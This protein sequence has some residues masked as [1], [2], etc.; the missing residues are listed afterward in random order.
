MDHKDESMS[1]NAGSGESVSHKTLGQ[2]AAER[3]GH[4]LAAHVF[5]WFTVVNDNG[6][7]RMTLPPAG[8]QGIAAIIDEVDRER[9]TGLNKK[10]YGRLHSDTTLS[11]LSEDISFL[12]RIAIRHEE[13]TVSRLA[14]LL[15]VDL[16]EARRIAKEELEKADEAEREALDPENHWRR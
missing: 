10:L 12:A 11:D 16:P 15:N 2:I 7:V 3:V 13:I 5:N 6:E 4:G 9:I 14:E 1:H 8:L